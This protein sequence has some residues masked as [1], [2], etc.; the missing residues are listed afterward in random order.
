MFFPWPQVVPCMY[1]LISACLNTWRPHSA[2][3]WI[4]F[5]VYLSP[6]W[7]S[8]LWYQLPWSPQTFNYISSTQGVQWALPWFP[9]FM[10]QLINSFELLSWSKHKAHLIFSW[11]LRDI[12]PSLSDVQC[13]INCCFKVLVFLFSL[14]ITVVSDGKENPVL[15][16]AS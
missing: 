5:S 9:L 8:T 1:W 15:V 13:L 10:T 16:I 4:S 12:C 2:D 6:F 7:C 11:S 3:L 14:L